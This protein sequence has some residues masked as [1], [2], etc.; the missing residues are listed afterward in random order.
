[1]C[2]HFYQNSKFTLTGTRQN[3]KFLIKPRY[4][5]LPLFITI[6]LPFAVTTL[7]ACSSIFYQR[8]KSIFRTSGFVAGI[9][10]RAIDCTIILLNGIL[11]A[12][13]RLF[14][15]AQFSIFWLMSRFRSHLLIIKIPFMPRSC[16]SW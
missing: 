10:A 4:F 6:P 5:G 1:M 8:G 15:C 13:S 2:K 11:P 3:S 7:F 12:R 16:I 9:S 14:F